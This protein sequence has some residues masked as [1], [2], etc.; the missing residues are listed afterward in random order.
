MKKSILLAACFAFAASVFAQK[1]QIKA[2]VNYLNDKNYPK[3]KEAIDAASIDESTKGEIRTWYI[4]STV[5][6]A[7]QQDPSGEGKDFYKDAGVSLKK[8]IE[9]QSDFEKTDID[10]RL[11]AVAVYYY[12]DGLTAFK[13]NN[14]DK[15]FENFGNVVSIFNTDASKR[16]MGRKDFDTVAR[17]SALYQGYS[18][19]YNK[20]YEA[21]LPFIEKAKNDPIVSSANTFLILAEIYGL[22]KDAAS[23]QKALADG[24][25]A[26]PQDKS[27][28]NAEINY[29]ILSGKSAELVVKLEDAIR[30]DNN[31]PDLLYILGTAYN[32]MAN[33]KDKDGKDLAKP[34]NFTELF[35]RAEI[36]FKAALSASPDHLDANYN[37]GALYFNRA[38]GINDK[39]NTITGTT[40][41]D[42]KKYDALK[43][44]RNEW[45]GKA[46]PFLEKTI[47][48][49]DGKVGTMKPEDKDTYVNAITS[50]K[51]IYGSL[52][53]T[54]KF[55]EMKKKQEAVK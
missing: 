9:L 46:L 29:Y 8:I 2:A 24:R 48:I 26:Y 31:N 36:A 35:D 23:Q 45:F 55:M 14:Y 44:E 42:L 5:Y 15:C 52:N 16:F 6:L 12:N 17:Q 50:A 19:Y 49:Y 41:A 47:A 54:D 51:T 27:L 3:A 22:R 7:M 20:N 4:R 10:K 37:T 1:S 28:Q 38:V 25:K 40:A 33:P 32:Q 11:F 53:K 39:M 43:S 21:A 34:T 18:A 13:N 30:N